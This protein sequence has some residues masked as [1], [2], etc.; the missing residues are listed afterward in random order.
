MSKKKLQTPIDTEM[1]KIIDARERFAIHTMFVKVVDK[2]LIADAEVE[3]MPE[4]LDKIKASMLQREAWNMVLS[5][6]MC[7]KIMYVEPPCRG[8]KDEQ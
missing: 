5:E 2:L 8:E 7:G 6:E 1:Q 4:G 3:A